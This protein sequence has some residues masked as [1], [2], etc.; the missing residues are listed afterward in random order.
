MLAARIARP[1]ASA[2]ICFGVGWRFATLITVRPISENRQPTYRAI[3]IADV[4]RPG[5]FDLERLFLAEEL[6]PCRAE[7]RVE[8]VRWRS[9]ELRFVLTEIFAPTVGRVARI[10]V[11]D[12]FADADQAVETARRREDEW[13]RSS[14]RADL[15]APGGELLELRSA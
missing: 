12:T 9:G 3:T 2:S 14:A 1:V 11:T 6:G 7:V 4:H 15:L 13:R 10:T 5:P 8:A